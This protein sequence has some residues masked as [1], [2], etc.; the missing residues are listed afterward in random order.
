MNTQNTAMMERTPF[1]LPDVA[2][3]TEFS[4]EELAEDMD[5]QIGRAHV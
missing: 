4:H 3:E 2:A 1:Q 5:G